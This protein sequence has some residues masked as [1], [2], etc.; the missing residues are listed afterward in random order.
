MR[1]A[2][3]TDA[4]SS[5][6]ARTGSRRRTWTGPLRICNRRRRAWR[7]PRAPCWRPT[8]V[9]RTRWCGRRSA[10]SWSQRHVE[11]GEMATVGMPL[12]TGLSLE[13]LRVAV[14]V[15]QSDIAAL[16]VRRRGLG[17]PARWRQPCRRTQS[18]SFPMRIHR[19]TPSGSACGLAEGQHGIYPGMWVKVRFHVG[20][21]AALL[22]PQ[23][24]VVQRS[25]LT[26]LYVLGDDGV[27]ASA[28]GPPRA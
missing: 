23:S 3:T 13:H 4:S 14:D 20:E 24:A 19:P 7:R 28:P 25:E 12:M 9:S 17:R 6:S 10:A 11:V 15:P 5:C 18:A 16:R 26:A 2:P 22:V 27:P 8:S 1:P 21:R